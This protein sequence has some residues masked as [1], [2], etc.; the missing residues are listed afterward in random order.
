MLR[1][2]TLRL[3]SWN[4]GQQSEPW[5]VLVEDDSIDVAL[6]Q[7]AT[8]PP[9]GIDLDVIVDGNW[10]LAGWQAR[11]FAAV[12]VRCSNRVEVTAEPMV[13]SVEAASANELAVSRP[14]SLAVATMSGP[15]LRAPI[16]VASIYAAW[17][18]P[19]PA[20]KRGW[21]YA[22]ASAHRIISDLS[23]LIDRQEGHRIIVSG[24]WNILHGYGDHGSD[25]WERRYRTVFDRLEAIG[26]RFVGPQMPNGQPAEHP[27]SELPAN[28]HDLPTYRTRR[29][30]PTSGQRQLDFV[31]ASE[32]IADSLTVRALNTTDEWGPSDH[33]RVSIDV[34]ERI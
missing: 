15:G 29:N 2:M 23:A 27:A 8:P 11:S 7:E 24:D 25:Y 17:D 13:K 6:L 5:R 3:I 1:Y 32:T 18:R 26:L 9:I 14:G 4:I 10:Q 20:K 28:S 34:D 22:D 31:F 19:L 12:I 16:I 30:D 33:C 21:I